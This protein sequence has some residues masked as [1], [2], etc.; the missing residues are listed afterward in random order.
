MDEQD[1]LAQRF[2]EHRTYLRAVAYRMLGSIGE[3]D[4]AVQE[5]W[6]RLSR[7]N[8][9]GALVTLL[10]CQCLLRLVVFRQ[11]LLDRWHVGLEG[12]AGDC[13]IYLTAFANSILAVYDGSADR[14]PTDRAQGDAEWIGSS[15][16]WRFRSRTWTARRPSTPRRPA[17]T[18]TMTTKSARRFASSS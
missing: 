11:C 10:G 17:S 16:W 3:A 14:P 13:R 2:E 9:R 6:L 18:R 4:A 15:N 5:A 1:W 12:G 7:S 8:I